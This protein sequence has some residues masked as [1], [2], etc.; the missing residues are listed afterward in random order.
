M[1]ECGT[2]FSLNKCASSDCHQENASQIEI[3][4]V[5]LSIKLKHLCFKLIFQYRKQ[6]AA[7]SRLRTFLLYP[8]H[9]DFVSG[10]LCRWQVKMPI[11]IAI[12]ERSRLALLHILSGFSRVRST[13]IA[14]LAI[15][16]SYLFTLCRDRATFTL[17]KHF[18]AFSRILQ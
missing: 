12:F 11:K 13:A 15:G 6:E 17:K 4:L 8:R 18:L 9:R 2:N 16:P 1:I 3:L 14:I 5:S 7:C 10:A